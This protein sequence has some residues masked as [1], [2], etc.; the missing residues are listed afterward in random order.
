[1]AL[2]DQDKDSNDF[3]LNVWKMTNEF[4]EE[5]LESFRKLIHAIAIDLNVAYDILIRLLVEKE[6]RNFEEHCL[7]TD[8][9][10]D[11]MNTNDCRLTSLLRK[12][13][14]LHS[15]QFSELNVMDKIYMKFFGCLARQN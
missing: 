14:L 1:M 15:F 13:D 8:W 6:K 12:Q 10:K 2:H 4:N 5:L 11:S 9:I 3:Y 7:I